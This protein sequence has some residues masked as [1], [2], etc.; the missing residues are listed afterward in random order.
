MTSG[1]T[2]ANNVDEKN[3][4][5]ENF[6]TYVNISLTVSSMVTSLIAAW[7]KKQQYVERIN[8]L[9]R[10]TQKINKLCEEIEFELLK[11]DKDRDNYSDFKDKVFPKISEYL[12]TNPTMSPSEWKHCVHNIIKNYPE[13]LTLDGTEDSKMWPWYGPPNENDVR[14]KT[15]FED[16]SLK[17]KNKW[18]WFW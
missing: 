8:S 14:D 9:D 10:Y 13:L 16:I 1:L 7:I 5:V 17:H 6:N 11:R 15:E 12:S 3:V 4:P 2:V 18:C